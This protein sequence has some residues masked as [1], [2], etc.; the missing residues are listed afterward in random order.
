MNRSKTR[1]G[2]RE[3]QQEKKKTCSFAWEGEL[4]PEQAPGEL[5]GCAGNEHLA[6][7]PF[8]LS[9]FLVAPP[10]QGRSTPRGA[11]S[12]EPGKARSASKSSS[13]WFAHCSELLVA[14]YFHFFG[15]D[16]HRYRDCN[17]YCYLSTQRI[18]GQL[19]GL[20]LVSRPPASTLAWQVLSTKLLWSY[21]AN[22]CRGDAAFLL[23]LS[24][25]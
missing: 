11:K 8:P 23:R 19:R 12:A 10:R 24:L 21:S 15:C 2:K 13:P 25:A 14:M 6:H 20:C 22:N 1:R 4:A 5:S 7:F 9:A 18:L 3:W 17:C 16:C